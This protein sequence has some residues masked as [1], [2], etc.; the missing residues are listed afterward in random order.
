MSE[1][2]TSC[3][4]MMLKL[5]ET[6]LTAKSHG[7]IHHVFNHYSDPDLLTQLY[8]PNGPFKPHLS[9]ICNGLNKLIEEGKLWESSASGTPNSIS[10][11]RP[12]RCWTRR[13][14]GMNFILS[15]HRV[16]NSLSLCSN[17][18]V[19]FSPPLFSAYYKKTT[20][21]ITVGSRKY[22]NIDPFECLIPNKW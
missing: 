22:R 15:T 20:F 8:N 11:K 13:K 9:K 6:H 14:Q 2:L 4:D 1:I 10:L 3:R 17:F 16:I 7:R 18:F 12:T 21:H 5:V 19:H